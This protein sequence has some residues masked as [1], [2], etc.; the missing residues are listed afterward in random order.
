MGTSCGASYVDIQVV[1]LPQNRAYYADQ[2]LR[3]TADVRAAIGTTVA[4]R[5][6]MIL[7]DGLTAFPAGSFYGLGQHYESDIPGPANPHNNGGLDAA[8]FPP[9]GYMPPTSSAE[10]GWYPGFWPEGM[11]HEV[12]HTLGAVNGSAPNAS[13]DTNGNARGH[14]TDGLDLMCYQD[15]PVQTARAPYTTSTCGS[16]AGQGGMTQTYDCGRDDYFS[17]APAPN[18]YLATHW[19]VFNSDFQAACE[20]VGGACGTLPVVAA[21]TNDAAPTITGTA[22]RMSVLSATR[23]NWTGESSTV[24]TWQ[25]LT[26]T[27]WEDILDA[28][29]SAATYTLVTA[30]VGHRVR[31]AETATNAL[32]STTA[33]SNELGPVVAATPANTGTKPSINGSAQRTQTLTA[34]HGD[35]SDG[36]TSYGYQWQRKPSGGTFA[37]IDQATAATYVPVADDIG[38][39]LLVQVTATN[40]DGPSAAVPSTAT[41]AVTD[42]PP[43]NNTAPAI[44]GTARRT[45]VLSANGGSWDRA[46][47]TSWTWQRETNG[48]WNDI[49]GVAASAPTY[50]L[51]PGDVGHSVRINE[52][53]TNSGGPTTVASNALGPV[54][55]ATPTNTEAAPSISGTAQRTRT[56][57]ASPGDSSDSPSYGYQWQRKPS[58]GTFGDIAQATAATYVPVAADVGSTLRVLV[59]ATNGGDTSTAVASAPTVTVTDLPPTNTTAAA[60]AGTARRTSVLT[61]TAGSWDRASSTTWTWQRETNGTWNDISGVAT[62]AATYTLAAADVGKRVRINETATNSG[63]PATLASN[64]LGP[65]AP[66]TPVN[67]GAAPSISGTAQR[68]RTLTASHGGWSDS[69]TSYGYQWQRKPSGGTFGDIA[70]A[71]ADTYVPTAGDVDATLRVQVTAT[72]GDGTSAAVPSA[73][74]ATVTDL[75]PPSTLSAPTM[76]GLPADGPRVGSQLGSTT[77]TWTNEPTG[78]THRWQRSADGGTFTDIPQ[79]TTSGYTLTGDDVGRQIRVLVTATNGDGAS[80]PVASAAT[81][82]VRNVAPV[83]QTAPTITGTTERDSTLTATTGTWNNAPTGFAIQWQLESGGAWQDIAGATDTSYV[84]TAPT[85]GLRLRVGVTATNDGGNATAFSEPVGPVTALPVVVMPDVTPPAPQP[86]SQPVPPVTPQP[87]KKPAAPVILNTVLALKRGGKTALRLR[88]RTVLTTATSTVSIAATKVKL[89]TGRY[90]LKLCKG[91]VCVTKAIVSKRGTA[92]LPALT[93]KAPAAGRLT[94]SLTGP[95]GVATGRA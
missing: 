49:S 3:I 15:G 18:S 80:P 11:L 59:T 61:A 16:V 24:W 91:A 84:L 28:E 86:P 13:M 43:T 37:D 45:S 29:P 69:P 83:V 94:A 66:A 39:T 75:H 74:T 38:A 53:A 93:L 60:I 30:D 2:F 21:P 9:L 40:G 22:R 85:V 78:Y 26:N 48:T 17:P 65:V 92:S 47:S 76:T 50:T 71:I 42:L 20:T 57:T 90:R 41:A 52:T 12:T 46:S 19:N 79:A 5:D 54:A 10:S 87:P 82:A 31:V 67:S 35:W 23:G 77:G 34:S 68:T 4:K 72:N 58:G 63:G 51:A 56:L 44:T 70:Q 89:P 14:C 25:R 73:S 95:G 33:P 7:A 55:P 1:A 36:A 32:G 88:V 27:T 81:V 62:S 6:L 8:L 64:T